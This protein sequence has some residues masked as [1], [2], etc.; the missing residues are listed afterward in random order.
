MADLLAASSLLLTILTILYSLWYPE[1]DE[2][3]RRKVSAHP[4][5][6]E[7]DYAHCRMVY[8]TKALP[9]TLFAIVISVINLPDSFGILY[10]AVSQIW[11][12]SPASYDA[13]KASF[14][15]VFFI[16]VFLASHTAVI[17]SK[18]AERVRLQKPN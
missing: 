3:I 7:G 15:A 10:F 18:L 17:T 6:R 5:D 1:I 12:S 2:A 16:M 9:L 8:R 14:V 13:A 4:E 11:S